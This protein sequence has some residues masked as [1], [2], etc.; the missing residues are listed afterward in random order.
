MAS[1]CE[2]ALV[3][4]TINYIY[5]MYVYIVALVLAYAN[6]LRPQF[7]IVQ[8]SCRGRDRTPKTSSVVVVVYW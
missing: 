7:I 8:S 5:L 2:E 4:D 1:N 6:G 3:S